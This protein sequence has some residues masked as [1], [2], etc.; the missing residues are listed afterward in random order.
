MGDQIIT[1]AMLHAQDAD[2]IAALEADLAAARAEVADLQRRHVE[3]DTRDEEDADAVRRLTAERDAFRS[4]LTAVMLPDFKDWHD[5]ERAEWPDI[6]AWVI[7]NLRERLA[8]AEAERDAA[9]A[10]SERRAT[11][12]L[13]MAEEGW[14]LHGEEGMDDM[15]KLVD[16]EVAL[17]VAAR[18]D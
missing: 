6:A 13:G 12:I 9:Q 16:A 18:G 15:Q 10:D 14:L 5:N 8:E 7:T 2:R 3:R 4:Q 1:N 17:I 11:I